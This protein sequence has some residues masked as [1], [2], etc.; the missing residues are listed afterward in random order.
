MRCT[1]RVI[2][3]VALV[4]T[5]GGM[6]AL[7]VVFAAPATPAPMLT[8][9]KMVAGT[10]HSMS[11]DPVR[12]TVH[13]GDT[14]RFIQTGNVPHNVVFRSVPKEVDADSLPQGP[15]LNSRGQSWDLVIDKRFIPGKYVYICT[16]HEVMGM[17]GI[18]YVQ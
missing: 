3:S 5:G 16:P 1:A 9:V 2:A 18:L 10:T 17:A 4:L 8:E 13:Q 11:Y 14:V 12:I 15:Y 6:V 7:P